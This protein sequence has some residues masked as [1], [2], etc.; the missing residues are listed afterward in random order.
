[1]S[2]IIAG[3]AKGLKLNIFPHL[4]MRPTT[5]RVKEALF[6]IIQFDIR[7]KTFLDLFSGTGQISLEALSRGASKVYAL[8]NSFESSRIIKKNISIF[9]KHYAD[10]CNIEFFY[11]DSFKFLNDFNSKVD[12]L[13]SDAPFNVDIS[14]EV[15]EKF[16]KVTNEIIITETLYKNV[17]LD[18]GTSF[19]LIK[20]YRYG[21]ISLNVYRNKKV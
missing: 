12:I 15:F 3:T 19:N 4:N 6:D 14:K 11:Y 10:K 9:K 16:E 1:M 20:R 2:R 7:G 5:N 8:D 17:P 21:R 13:F 18:R